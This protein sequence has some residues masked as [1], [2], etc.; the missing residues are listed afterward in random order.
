MFY[1]RVKSFFWHEEGPDFIVRF[2]DAPMDS[3]ELIPTP[4]VDEMI[5]CRHRFCEEGAEFAGFIHNE[6]RYGFY[7]VD[8]NIVK[9]QYLDNG[10]IDCFNVRSFS[11]LNLSRVTE[12][13]REL[14]QEMSQGS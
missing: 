3:W 6:D 2:S 8:Q 5:R 13:L 11:K 1:E 4:S 10:E 12:E 7:F 9:A 14:I